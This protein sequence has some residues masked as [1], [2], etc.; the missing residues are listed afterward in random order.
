MVRYANVPVLPMP[1]SVITISASEQRVEYG[2]FLGV[3]L[4]QRINRDGFTIDSFIGYDAGYRNVSIDPQYEREFSSVS[5]NHFSQTFRFGL[6]FGY[7]F[8]FVGRIFHR[9]PGSS[10]L[11]RSLKSNSNPGPVN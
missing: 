5:T 8:S 6:N 1:S 7:S 9:G 3:R 11:I 4:M 10:G 2:L